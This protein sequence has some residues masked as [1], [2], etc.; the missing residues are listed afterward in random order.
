[1]PLIKNFLNFKNN[2]YLYIAELF[3]KQIK[4]KAYDMRDGMKIIDAH[5][6]YTG[7]FKPKEQTLLEYM[8]ENGIDGAIVNTLNTNANMD[9]LEKI[10]PEILMEKLKDRT[11]YKIFEDFEAAGQPSHTEVIALYKRFPKRIYPFFWYNNNDPNDPDQ[12]KGIAIVKEALNNGF[13]GV[14]IQPAMIVAEMERLNPI[15]ELLIQYDYPLYIHPSGGVFAS[16]R[17][18]PFKI[19]E[20]SKRNPNLKIIIGHSAYTMEFV[21][22]TVIAIKSIGN[23][24]KNVYFESSVSIPFGILS[25]IKVFGSDHVIF[26]SDSPP[27]GP[28]EV[29]YNKI[30]K[31][32]I[33]NNIKQQI[34]CKN[35]EKLLG[36]E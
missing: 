7:I 9:V 34:F 2:A 35:I 16:P 19:A 21:I 15:A 31:L 11:K 20:L 18:D 12:S 3:L 28:W 10:S 32:K 13:K 36:L 33:P 26:G 22:E 24:S 4:T 6:H 8:D 5:M 23:L 27:A 29:E 14:K 17:T 1:M 30:A 25:Y